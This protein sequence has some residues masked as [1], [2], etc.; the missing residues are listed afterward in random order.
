MLLMLWRLPSGLRRR[1]VSTRRR[2]GSHVRSNG[3]SFA[4]VCGRARSSARKSWPNA[5][6]PPGTAFRGALARLAQIGT[7]RSV[8]G[9]PSCPLHSARGASHPKRFVEIL[10][11]EAAALR[12]RCRPRRKQSGVSRRSMMPM[13][14]RSKAAA[15]STASMRRTTPSTQTFGVCRNDFLVS[16]IHNYSAS[17]P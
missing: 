11:R 8:T 7:S 4:G 9:A 1:R 5:S 3:I 2:T 14:R 10:Q 6:M 13:K 15:I 17:H 12:S 16:I